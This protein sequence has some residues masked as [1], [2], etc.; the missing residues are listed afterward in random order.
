MTATPQTAAEPPAAAESRG[1][2]IPRAAPAPRL[3]RTLHLHFLLGH[4]CP[5]CGCRATGIE[6]RTMHININ[7]MR[8]TGPGLVWRDPACPE[9]GLPTG[10]RWDYRGLDP[11]DQPK[12][13]AVRDALRAR[14]K[15]AA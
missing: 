2:S 7:S 14:K 13:A 15:K 5:V 6:F 4:T 11:A 9:C 10:D 12:V 8:S 3:R 1:C